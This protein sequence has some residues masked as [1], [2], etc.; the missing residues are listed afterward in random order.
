ML[1]I[2]YCTCDV[3]E[4]QQKINLE[5][6]ERDNLISEQRS[7]QPDDVEPQQPQ[8]Q[9]RT[10]I[11]HASQHSYQVRVEVNVMSLC[12]LLTYIQIFRFNTKLMASTPMTLRTLDHIRKSTINS[13]M[14]LKNNTH[15]NNRYIS[16]HSHNNNTN[17]NSNNNSFTI[18]SNTY[19]MLPFSQNSI[20]KPF[21]VIGIYTNTSCT[22]IIYFI[23]F[24]R[25]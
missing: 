6:I 11:V 23:F 19:N 17:L 12:S 8:Q 21:K 5:D 13:I 22:F 16:I 24:Y 14:V 20:Q 7:Q 2:S 9:L 25:I 10:P 18:N 3:S 15:I 1:F 4:L